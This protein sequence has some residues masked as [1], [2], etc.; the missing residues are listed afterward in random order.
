MFN[1]NDNQKFVVSKNVSI[2]PESIVP[3]NPTTN[4]P[5]FMLPMSLGFIDPA[6]LF[7][8]Y[9]LKMS[10]RGCYMPDTAAGALS[11]WRDCRIQTGDGRTTIEDLQDMNVKT[12]HDNNLNQN[13][14]INNR[15]SLY[16]GKSVRNATKDNQLFLSPPAPNPSGAVDEYEQ[17]Q[18]Q[19]GL[20]QSG[21]L[22]NHGRVFPL[23]ATDGLRISL[24]LDSVARS[25]VSWTN[26]ADKVEENSGSGMGIPTNP[27]STADT[28]TSFKKGHWNNYRDQRA[29]WLGLYGI[30]DGAAENGLVKDTA[31]NGE[32]KATGAAIT[33]Q[34]IV[35]C[36]GS[37]AECPTNPLDQVALRNLRD[38][39]EGDANHRPF[40]VG[41]LLY[42]GTATGPT[43]IGG[44]TCEMLGV[45]S[46]FA[47]TVRAGQTRAVIKYY[48]WGSG[49][50]VAASGEAKLARDYPKGSAIFVNPADRMVR[51][52]YQVAGLRVDAVPANLRVQEPVSFE[53]T[54][55][56][57]VVNQV[58]P[59]DAYVSAL[60]N[61]VSKS[62]LNFDY[63]T[64]T[65]YR[66]NQ[67]TKT[68]LTN[69][70]IPAVQNKAYSVVSVPLNAEVQNTNSDPRSSFKGVIDGIQNYQYVVGSSLQPNRPVDTKRYN[71]PGDE[72]KYEP[73]HMMEL[74]KATVSAMNSVRS[75]WD[76]P[77][78]F[79][80]GRAFSLN[81]QV[82]KLNGKDLAL[83]AEYKD[84]EVTKL[85]QH[86]I[87][88]V[89]TLN[90]SSDGATVLR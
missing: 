84:G 46:G 57:L 11:L 10:G 16:E 49:R 68:G 90:I 53:I 67:E 31:D 43:G 20:P 36:N 80:V 44:P 63:K 54:D 3:Y 72:A 15:R 5:R 38:A 35:L 76:L 77:N 64:V 88:H 28:W 2:K 17:I 65:M 47:T 40:S 74:E 81:G 6:S 26:N 41:D 42:V 73:L 61:Q 27:A 21:I 24:T 8:K 86:Y 14:S 30:T 25:I 29:D 48:A 12:S 82:H 70:M 19:H 62:G 87:C 1:A 58:T 78:D 4:N 50:T 33:E 55:L 22:G 51:A 45:V 23:L 13:N 18:I 52:D 59:P 9:N 71:S 60:Q 34:Q 37:D 56:E 7:L 79:S 39:K 85:F 75:W 32:V 69:Q 66:H 89:N 83:R